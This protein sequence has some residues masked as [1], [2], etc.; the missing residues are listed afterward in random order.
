[1]AGKRAGRRG[2]QQLQQVAFH[3]QHHHLRL[4]VAEAGIVFH[5][6]GPVRRQHQPGIEHTLIRRAPCC[7]P[8]DRRPDHPFQGFL[9]YFARHHRRR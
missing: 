5:E 9:V 4:G 2:M 6:L 1:M 8:L 3:A 7:Q